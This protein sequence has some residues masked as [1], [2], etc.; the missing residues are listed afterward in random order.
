[1]AD[2]QEKIVVAE[3]HIRLSP[4]MCATCGQPFHGWGRQRF[5]SLSCQRRWDYLRHADARRTRRRE[6]Y[7]TQKQATAS[8][9]EGGE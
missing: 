9:R 1:M 3:R 7:Q 2:S 8:Q 6:R 5:C 4:R